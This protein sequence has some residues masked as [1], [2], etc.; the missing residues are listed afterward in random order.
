MAGEEEETEAEEMTGKGGGSRLVTLLSSRLF[1]SSGVCLSVFLD[2][3]IFLEATDQFAQRPL[4]MLMRSI[5]AA[6]FLY[7]SHYLNSLESFTFLR[8]ASTSFTFALVV[9]ISFTFP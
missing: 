2:H 8:V 9:S 6:N 7:L 1:A 3:C 5:Y 4:P